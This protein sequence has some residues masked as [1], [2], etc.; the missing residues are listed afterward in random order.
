MNERNLPGGEMSSR[1]LDF[2][3]IA[4]CSGS[5]NGE[6]IQTLNYAIRQT[7]P[8]MRKEADANPNA[9]IMVRAVKF[10]DGA[11][12]HVPTATLIDD[13]NWTDLSAGGVTAMGMALELVAGEL[14]QFPT[15]T[16]R[17][18][19]VL[20]LLT[21]GQPT[22]DF[23]RGLDELTATPWGKKAVRIAIAIGKDVDLDVLEQF[24]GNKELVL[25]AKNPQLLV[26]FIKWASTVVKNVSAPM[27][28]DTGSGG[29][30][31]VNTIPT[32]SV[33]DDDIW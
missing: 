7:I 6:K 8:D 32:A 31:D 14:K 26:K 29:A 21:D 28:S 16:K 5:M 19:P 4:D 9:S 12:W 1:I 3:W 10:S 30:I 33:D 20:V 13:F 24:A 15:D 2:F 27:V 11:A 25:E 17:L 23:K 22:D 18:P